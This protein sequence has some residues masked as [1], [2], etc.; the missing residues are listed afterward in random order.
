MNSIKVMADGTF[1]Y[2]IT[3][4]EVDAMNQPHNNSV[5]KQVHSCDSSHSRQDSFQI[6]VRSAASNF[7]NFSI[8]N[9]EFSSCGRRN[10][11]S[12]RELKKHVE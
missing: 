8:L 12:I 5:L 9:L 10:I 1:H 4:T 7:W 11:C 6:R 2:I 3:L